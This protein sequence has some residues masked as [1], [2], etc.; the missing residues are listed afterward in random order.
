MNDIVTKVFSKRILVFLLMLPFMVPAFLNSSNFA[1]I[2]NVFDYLKAA[3]SVI[4]LALFLI[5]RK[6]S[7]GVVSIILFYSSFV[8]TSLINSSNVFRA[9][10]LLVSTVTFSLLLT[11]GISKN[12]RVL[13]DVLTFFIFVL[14]SGEFICLFLFPNGITLH[15]YYYYKYGFINID[16]QLAPFM[17]FSFLILLCNIKN[18]SN[19]AISIISL[20]AMFASVFITWSATCV[21]SAL[22]LLAY[23]FLFYR[24]KAEAVFRSEW[25]LFVIIVAFFAIVVFRIQDIFSGFIEGF[26]GKSITL[27]GRTE[28]WDLT[29]NLIVRSPLF[30]YGYYYEGGWILW[31]NR[32]YYSHNI[33]LEILL[34]GGIFSMVFFVIM[35]AMNLSRMKSCKDRTMT[36][37]LNVCMLAFGISCLTE[38][39]FAS[40]YFP[41]LL[42]YA[43][44]IDLLSN[45]NNIVSVVRR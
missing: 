12:L 22:V 21:V 24:K 36:S 1:S 43:Y 17:I 11:L 41:A 2:G 44:N 37:L 33:F 7:I 35:V 16:N 13:N 34:I 25:I 26:L 10:V 38:S 14:W 8:I 20:V 32:Y 23:L 27:T 18:R 9:V 45:N 28:I 29:F 40:I 39:Y 15:D 5:I 19:T 31:H 6:I 3:S 30:G 4:I 42:V